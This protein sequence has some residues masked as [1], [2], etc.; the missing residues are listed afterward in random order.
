MALF[1][2]PKSTFLILGVSLDRLALGP[3]DRPLADFHDA[4]ITCILASATR[5]IQ[6]WQSSAFVNLIPRSLAALMI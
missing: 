5:S 4:S 1:T 2:F 3:A 6:H